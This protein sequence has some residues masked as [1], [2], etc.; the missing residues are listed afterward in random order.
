MA[1][2]KFG[3]TVEHSRDFNDDGDRVVA[4]TTTWRVYLPHQCDD[5]DIAG[6]RWE[7]GESRAD[8]VAELE[9]F[10]AEAQQA[11]EALKGEQEFPAAP[12]TPETN[13]P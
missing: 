12:S 13:Q 3:F 11:L 4:D 9:A 8:A 6:G 5:W 10:I 7:G 1:E 2:I